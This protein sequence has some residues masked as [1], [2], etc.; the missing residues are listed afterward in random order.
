MR[1]RSVLAKRDQ[2]LELL[3]K[4]YGIAA[5]T[6]DRMIGGQQD[7]PVKEVM[8]TISYGKIE[9][10]EDIADDASVCQAWSIRSFLEAYKKRSTDIHIEPYRG[11]LRLRYRIDG[12]LCEQTVPEEFSRFFS[13]ILSRIKIMA[14]SEYCRTKDPSGWKG[15]CQDTGPGIRS[16]SI[17]H[18]DSSR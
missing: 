1:S 13:P 10:I 3:K 6:V 18:A 11:K 5:D 16:K 15:N 12:K 14:N 7:R 8:S 9:N 4:H 17:I 2:I